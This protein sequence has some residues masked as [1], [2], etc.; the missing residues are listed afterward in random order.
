MELFHNPI[1]ARALCLIIGYAFGIFQTAYIYGKFHKVDIRDVGS[2]NAG[3]TNTLRTFGFKAGLLVFIGDFVKP[4][5]A[6]LVVRLIF[7]KIFSD[8]ITLLIL[9]A[10]FGAILGHN[11]PFYL[12]FHGGKGIAT[13]AGVFAALGCWQLDL[14]WFWSFILTVIIT[15]YV[16]AGSLIMIALEYGAFALFISLG[17]IDGG[18]TIAILYEVLIVAFV[19]SGFAFFR[20]KENIKRLATG[21]E[22]VLSFSFFKKK[23]K[24]V[25][26]GE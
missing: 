26:K 23:S 24:D 17:W 15:R 5:L 7:G 14:V 18:A 20:H 9:Y 21:T 4:I 13:T 6:S 11:Y 16:S 25:P 1:F 12:K 22:N 3:T 10:G 8:S 19:I 2:G